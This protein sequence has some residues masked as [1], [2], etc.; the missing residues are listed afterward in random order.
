MVSSWRLRAWPLARPRFAM[1]EVLSQGSSVIAISSKIPAV[2]IA[3]QRRVLAS[4]VLIRLPVST[5]FDRPSQP[6]PYCFL[7]VTPD[8]HQADRQ[9]IDAATWHGE[10]RMSGNIEGTGVGL[11]VKGDV[12]HG[13]ERRIGR[14][15]RGCGKGNGRHR[16]RVAL[17]QRC[18][19]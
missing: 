14:R 12:D 18:V 13:V 16:Q 5:G 6:Y 7:N 1:I 4:I 10:G 17:L 15:D 11:H 9:T 2:Q 8:Q 3:R 19:G